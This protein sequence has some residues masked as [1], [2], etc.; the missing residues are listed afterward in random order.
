MTQVSWKPRAFLLEGFLTDEECEHL[1]NL[2][3]P[4][5][6]K[7]SVV[8]SE[9]G[10]SFDSQVRTSQG[11]FLRKS[12]DEVIA[13]IERRIATVTHMP[14]E[15]GESMQVLRYG[16]NQKYDAHPDYFFDEKNKD[17]AHGGQRAVTFLMYLSTPEEGGE[18]CFPYAESKVSGPGWSN[19]AL[20]GLSV[21]AIK[22]NA[23][24]F[25]DLK[26]DGITEDPRSTHMA[27]PVLKGVK[28]SAPTWIHRKQYQSNGN[29]SYDHCE[30]LEDGCEEWALAGECDKNPGFM[31]SNCKRSCDACS[32]NRIALGRRG[33]E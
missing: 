7:S 17:E 26:P 21:K 30:D 32:K 23:V 25:H 16:L 19:C 3:L 13:R 24:L 14:V 4:S 28:W 1:I 5:I 8:N 12:Q 27:C 6:T 9:T 2:A 33:I 22:G 10:D 11:M 15:N 18:T 31:M 20:Q 29:N